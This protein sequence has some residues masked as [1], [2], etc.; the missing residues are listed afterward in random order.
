MG[1]RVLV[2]ED[3]PH[4][5]ELM[6]H[7]LRAHGHTVVPATTGEQAVELAEA[8]PPD[9]VVMDLRLP[10]IDGY[11]ALSEL[12]ARP[13]LSRT[14]VI[15]VTSFGDREQALGAGFAG[16]LAKPISPGTFAADIDARLPAHLRGQRTRRIL[17]LDDSPINLAL[18]C[19]MLEPQG[20]EVS[21]ATSVREA[22]ETAQR[23]R[24]DLVLCDVDRGG[25]RRCAQLM[26]QL[27]ASPAG[28]DV[29]FAFL[30]A[31]ADPPQPDR[32]T[33]MIR[34]PV[35]PRQLLDGVNALLD[36]ADEG[37]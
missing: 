23:T 26:S 13:R 34:R 20:Y 10:G 24:P 30:T 7:L 29:R 9:L 8:Q 14:P 31:A 2:V 19:S 32:R 22:V 4:S 18:L 11:Q 37:G 33:L 27:R 25:R 17:I 36:P 6:T 12:R 16:Y 21:T 5:L 1:A 15:A 35:E 3:T 28:R